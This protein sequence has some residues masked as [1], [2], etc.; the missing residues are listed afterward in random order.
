MAL[1]VLKI[2][3]IAVAGSLFLIVMGIVSVTY[4]MFR[5]HKKK[6]AELERQIIATEIGAPLECANI[7]RPPIAL[8]KSLNLPNNAGAGWGILPSN[9]DLRE[10]YE[11]SAKRRPDK[12]KSDML[13]WPLPRRKSSKKALQMKKIRAPRLST[14]VES[15]RTESENAASTFEEVISGTGIAVS[16]GAE[17]HSF[18]HTTLQALDSTMVTR[19]RSPSGSPEPDVSPSEALKPALLRF[20]KRGSELIQAGQDRPPL[21]RA[22]TVPAMMVGSEDAVFG[23]TA[24]QTHRHKR[25]SRSISIGQTS[26][27]PSMPPPP[28]PIAAKQ[29]HPAPALTRNT[30]S[31]SVTSLE[32]VGSSLMKTSVSPN[33]RARNEFSARHPEMGLVPQVR[34]ANTNAQDVLLAGPQQTQ[35][36]SGLRDSPRLKSSTASF[37]MDATGEGVMTSHDTANAFVDKLKHVSSY[38]REAS[39]AGEAEHVQPQDRRLDNP[40][41]VLSR[42][43]EISSQNRRVSDEFRSIDQPAYDTISASQRTATRPMPARETSETSMQSSESSVSEG[44]RFHWDNQSPVKLSALKGSPNARKSHRRQNCVRISVTPTVWGPP[45]RTSSS[46][47][48]FGIAEEEGDSPSSPFDDSPTL[49]RP[50][51]A[52]LF[53]PKL[54]NPRAYRASLKTHSPALSMDDYGEGDLGLRR[55]SIRSCSRSPDRRQS[56][57]SS[58]LSI[59]IFPTR[60]DLDTDAK[61]DSQ[62][63][64]EEV[65]TYGGASTQPLRANIPGLTLIRN[66]GPKSTEFHFPTIDLANSPES[67]NQDHTSPHPPRSGPASP[68]ELLERVLAV[69][70]SLP[71]SLSPPPKASPTTQLSQESLPSAAAGITSRPASAHPFDNKPDFTPRDSQG[72]PIPSHPLG[73]R[74]PPAPSIVKTVKGLRRDN[75]EAFNSIDSRSTRRYLSI[76]RSGSPNLSMNSLASSPTLTTFSDEEKENSPPLRDGSD[77]WNPT[78]GVWAEPKSSTKAARRHGLNFET[79]SPRLRSGK[80]VAW[81]GVDYSGTPLAGTTP[82]SLYDERGFYIGDDSP[83]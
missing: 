8:R 60:E 54:N 74:A 75:S 12:R 10:E 53:E 24:R 4:P 39:R 83:L 26:S 13:S 5:I 40:I 81:G 51:S 61:R 37:L 19:N 59:P 30:S 29:L 36:S 3:L 79:P 17:E 45:S 6:I 80:S 7:S 65:P 20:S 58:V 70:A 62:D 25:N 73:P 42:P 46:T 82:A 21:N 71:R 16:P 67:S 56:T 27:A 43:A 33:M 14:V 32:S 49:H 41:K 2:V 9:E 11:K 18:E 78:D 57:A 28:L 31:D 34:K 55:N 50:P 47:R 76:G 52:S 35:V 22:V 44:N 15:P 1:G 48:I 23:D 63:R 77:V 69:S 72:S 68:T 64:F 66:T 38:E